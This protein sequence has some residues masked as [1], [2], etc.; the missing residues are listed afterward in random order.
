MKLATRL[1]RLQRGARHTLWGLVD[2]HHPLLV[3]LVATRRCNLSCAYCN[4]YDN[5]SQPVPL[6][7]MLRRV[8]RLAEL[9]TTAVTVSGGEPLMHPELDLIVAG[10]RARDMFATLITNGY[11]LSRDWILRLNRA[12]LDHLQISIDNVEP[13]SVSLKS[14]R[15]LEPKLRWLARYRDFSVAI[16]S[17]IGSGVR[18]PEDALAVAR[19]A[20]ELGFSTSLGIAHDGHGQL[21]AL[22]AREMA[23]YRELRSLEAVRWTRVNSTFQENLSRGLPNQWSCR[24]GARYLYVDEQGLVHYC[25]Q[26]RGHPAIPL[27]RYSIQDIRREY[28]TPKSC[29]PYCTI[30]C[31]QQVAWADRLRAPQRA[32][33]RALDLPARPASEGPLSPAAARSNAGEAGAA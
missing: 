4:E 27:E 30:N 19:R 32:P 16:N 2:R 20:R 8:E 21:Q 12:G 24:A 17:V 14:L 18:N 25:S 15:L 31:V 23:V 29:A 1:N 10:I 6:P 5:V 22:S 9:G 13:D 26:Q 33:V 28:D 7:V 3:H 11:F